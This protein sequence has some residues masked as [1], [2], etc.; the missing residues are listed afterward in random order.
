MPAQC[1]LLL[2]LLLPAAVFAGPA[3]DPGIVP[4]PVA[5]PK[6]LVVRDFG[7]DLEPA[8]TPIYLNESLSAGFYAP[9]A[10]HVELADDLHTTLVVPQLLC[11]FDLGYF[12]PGVGLVDATV[13]FYANGPDDPARGS[14]LAGPY[15]VAGLPA[16][17]HAF[18]IEVAGAMLEGNVWM[19]VAFSDGVSG[20][21]CFGPP[22]LGA[23]HDL[24]WITP[25]GDPSGFASDFD[26]NPPA[27]L[28]LGVSTSPATPASAA[29]WGRL[30]AVYR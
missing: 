7:R 19:G 30:K 28:F 26:G 22:T 13:T 15:V 20:L 25:P 9:V 11:G 23:S 2:L 24:V 29:T 1:A 18:H 3:P 12:K 8:C 6:P 27:N 21:L 4:L 17:V 16:G 14:V 5:V 10:A